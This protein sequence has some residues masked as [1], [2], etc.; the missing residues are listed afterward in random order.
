VSMGFSDVRQA[1]LFGCPTA[2]MPNVW[3]LLFL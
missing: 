1:D 3:H 2:P